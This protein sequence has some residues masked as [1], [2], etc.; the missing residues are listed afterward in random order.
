[1]KKGEVP[2][3]IFQKPRIERDFHLWRMNF[4]VINKDEEIRNDLDEEFYELVIAAQADV[5]KGS[6]YAFRTQYRNA[7]YVDFQRCQRMMKILRKLNKGFEKAATDG[8]Y[9]QTFA[10]YVGTV[11]RILKVKYI[12][13]DVGGRQYG[14]YDERNFDWLSIEDGVEYIHQNE[15]VFKDLCA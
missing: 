14:S 8:I 12:L 3:I 6:F 9:P 11:C 4:V 10:E 1:M 5:G 15:K 7:Y 13:L 2:A